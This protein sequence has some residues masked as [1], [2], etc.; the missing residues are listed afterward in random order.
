MDVRKIV[1][2]LDDPRSSMRYRIVQVEHPDRRR[3]NWFELSN[4]TD[5]MGESI[6][7]PCLVDMPGVVDHILV[8]QTIIKEKRSIDLDEV[9]KEA[10]NLAKKEIVEK[11]LPMVE[12]LVSNQIFR[13][14]LDKF[15]PEDRIG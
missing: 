11:M 14:I 2:E 4:R 7:E 3:T 8:A 9:R 15:K 13:S 1:W 6:W 10:A 5:M 12:G